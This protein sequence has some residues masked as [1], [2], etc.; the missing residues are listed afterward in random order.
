MAGETIDLEWDV[1]EDH[2][3]S[4]GGDFSIS[5][6]G[7]LSYAELNSTIPSGVI[8][9]ESNIVDT[10]IN[11]EEAASLLTILADKR[12]SIQGDCQGGQRDQ[13]RWSLGWCRRMALHAEKVS[14][15]GPAERMNFFFKS[16]D[17]G[18][19]NRVA[20][21][22][23]KIA[24]ECGSPVTGVAKVFCSDRHSF[25]RP[26][27]IAYAYGSDIVNC[28]LFF[29]LPTNNKECRANT[30]ATTMIHEASHLSQILGT[31][32][33]N[34]CYGIDCIRSL[35]REQNLNHADTYS[36]FAQGTFPAETLLSVAHD[37]TQNS[38]E[39]RLLSQGSMLSTSAP[40]PSG[41]RLLLTIIYNV[42]LSFSKLP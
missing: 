18:T 38:G 8:Q 10:S 16:S 12:A 21:N 32:D 30:Q 4:I 2:D 40:G 37:L 33:Y 19:R 25:C 29:R 23:H 22:F 24:V 13:T 20:D 15:S 42:L 17:S 9:Y 36:F 41:M 27:Y 7:S 28:P 34:G 5:S 39:F 11:G 35:S 1:A 3:L 14:R 6:S 31:S 26:E